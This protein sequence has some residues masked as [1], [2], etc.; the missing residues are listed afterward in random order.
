MRK[1]EAPLSPFAVQLV[2]TIKG[3]AC[4]TELEYDLFFYWVGSVVCQDRLQGAHLESN[5]QGF[6]NWIGF[7]IAL[8][9]ATEFIAIFSK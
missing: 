4:L 7:K 1:F 2:L 6:S 5:V 9:S 8:T 3:F